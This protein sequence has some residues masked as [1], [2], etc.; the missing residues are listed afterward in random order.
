MKITRLLRKHTKRCVVS[1]KTP[2]VLAE[3]QYL[4]GGKHE[5]KGYYIWRCNDSNCRARIAIRDFVVDK[6]PHTP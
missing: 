1:K 4:G 2:W 5:I 6:L 3:H